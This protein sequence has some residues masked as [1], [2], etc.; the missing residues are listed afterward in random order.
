VCDLYAQRWRIEEAFLL[1]KRLLGLAYLWVGGSNGVQIQLYATWIFY[2][3]LMDLCADV[4]VALRQPLERIS[5]EM[6]F[7]SLYHFSRARQQG[8]A[9][10][11]LP[12]LV[13]FH[14]AFGLVKAQRQRQRRRQA[15]ALDIWAKTL[16]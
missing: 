7:R 15:Q 4:A 3:V 13:Q 9:E 8:R 1:T 6:V 10:A 2:A 16:S 5:V 14:H 12:F 11:L